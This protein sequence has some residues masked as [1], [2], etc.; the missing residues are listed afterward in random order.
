MDFKGFFNVSLQ[1]KIYMAYGFPSGTCLMEILCI[2]LM[3]YLPECI[4][5]E[6]E[7]LE[8]FFLNQQP[9]KYTTPYT[10]GTTEWTFFIM[11]WTHHL[12]YVL[13]ESYYTLFCY[14]TVISN[15]IQTVW[16]DFQQVK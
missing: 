16:L 8:E 5:T 4:K 13:K 10:H 11:L 7:L 2:H 14:L 1:K 3:I 6:M 15:V 12:Q 9:Y